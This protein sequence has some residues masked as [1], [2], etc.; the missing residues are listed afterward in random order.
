M[1]NEAMRDNWA[2]GG[3]AWVRNERIFDHVFT[4]ITATLIAAADLRGA[5]RLLDVGCGTGTLLTR[6]VDAGVAAVGVDISEPMVTAARAR[7]PEAE[8]VLADAQEADL[9]AL[10]PADRIVSRFGVMF[11]DDPAAAFTNI[12][13]A[14]A[15]G[16]RLAFVCWRA[17]ETEMFE[18]GLAP[19]REHLPDGA[20]PAPQV[21]APGPV[22]F[23][24]RARIEEVLRRAGWADATIEAADVPCDYGI[25]G[26]DGVDARLA[27]ALAGS[28]GRA[29]RAA[30][31]PEL[32]QA[33][34][35]AIVEQMRADLV[36]RRTGGTLQLTAH[37]WLVTA[38]NPA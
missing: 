38:Q 13:R 10:G 14:A 21:G 7:V 12:R 26:T 27:V 24:E 20:L 22:G 35:D 3:E 33:G 11:F 36:A 30:L 2:V 4:D 19:L 15:P 17:D 25:D 6:A 23:G 28:V 5:A 9:A 34:W 16:A 29:A 31:E 8:V 18:L 37:I 32:G 1:A